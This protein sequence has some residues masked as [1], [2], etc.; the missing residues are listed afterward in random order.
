MFEKPVA[1]FCDDRLLMRKRTPATSECK[2]DAVNQIVVPTQF[3][4]HVL[5]L[6]HDHSFSDH[7]GIKKTILAHF[8]SFL[9]AWFKI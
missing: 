3:C 9:L 8:T 6:A 1:Y 7:L 4:S 5:M 2:A